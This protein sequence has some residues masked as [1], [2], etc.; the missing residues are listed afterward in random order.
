[1]LG[2]SRMYLE[3]GGVV[4]G[5]TQLTRNAGNKLFGLA[6]KTKLDGTRDTVE[7]LGISNVLK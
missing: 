1:M 2:K 5:F 7:K 6:R 4:D 3:R